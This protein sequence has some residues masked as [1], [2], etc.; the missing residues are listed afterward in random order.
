MA[1]STRPT[2]DSFVV[3]TDA[4]TTILIIVVVAVGIEDVTTGSLSV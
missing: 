1:M 4:V 3:L 2:V